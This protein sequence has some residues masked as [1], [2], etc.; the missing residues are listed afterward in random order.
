MPINPAD[1]VY[2]AFSGKGKGG[3]HRNRHYCC[4]RAR[5]VP[6]GLTAVATNERSQP[7]NKLAALKTLEEKLAKLSA[8]ELQARNLARRAG[9]AAPSFGSAYVRTY[10]LDGSDAGLVDHDTKTKWPLS[11]FQQKH[12]ADLIETRNRILLKLRLEGEK[13]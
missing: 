4:I 6:T 1:V 13:S 12:L 5:H 9:R 7:Q 3:Q 8:A 11:E 10:R 2:E